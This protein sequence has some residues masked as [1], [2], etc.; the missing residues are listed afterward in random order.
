MPFVT[1][2]SN[3][4]NYLKYNIKLYINYNR[5]IEK[6]RNSTCKVFFFYYVAYRKMFEGPKTNSL[7]RY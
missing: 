6:L 2:R 3:F 4:F 5:Y 7:E 1:T